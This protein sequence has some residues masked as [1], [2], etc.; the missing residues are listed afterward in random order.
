MM[1]GSITG[2]MYMLHAPW[3]VASLV[4]VELFP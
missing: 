3:K 4:M 2:A 1:C